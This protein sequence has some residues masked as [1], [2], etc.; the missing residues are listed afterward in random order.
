MFSKN[1]YVDIKATFEQHLFQLFSI[2]LAG[3]IAYNN[4]DHCKLM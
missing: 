1:P 4:I 2:I 3:K